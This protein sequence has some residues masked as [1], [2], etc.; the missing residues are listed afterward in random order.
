MSV[1][2]CSTLTEV[3]RQISSD[4]DIIVSMRLRGLRGG[5]WIF[6]TGRQEGST[7]FWRRMRI[8]H[9]AVLQ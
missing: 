3:M 7:D 9:A 5:A 8:N 4:I 2:E 6:Q 1:G